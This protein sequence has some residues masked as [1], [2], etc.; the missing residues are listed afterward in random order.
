MDE[1]F[2]NQPPQVQPENQYN[3][4]AEAPTGQ[5][6]SP[7]AQPVQAA[8]PQ[9]VPVQPQQYVAPAQA[10]Q[11]NAP[12]QPQAQP[13]AQTYEQPVYQ[14]ISSAP[15]VVVGGQPK[16]KKKWLVPVVALGVVLLSGGGASAYYFGVYQK[17]ENVLLDAFNKLTAAKAVRSDTVITLNKNLSTDMT[18]KDIKLKANSAASQS[19]MM[20]AS[21]DFEYKGKAMP[22]GAKGFVSLTDSTVYFQINN[23]KEALKTVVDAENA[24]AKLPSG[25]LDGIGTL[26]DQW[27][28]VTVDD[29][30]KNNQAAG[31]NF[32]C[33]VNV[34][35]KHGNDSNQ[36]VLD[37]YK[38]NPFISVKESLGVKD[39]R[40]GY[41]L[42]W[43]DVKSKAFGDSLEQTQFVK[44]LKACNLDN[45]SSSTS[46]SVD[47]ATADNTVY[48][49]W[50]DQWTHELK[51]VEFNGTSG[52]S[53]DKM[54]FNG[55]V[56]VAYDPNVKVEAP[57]QS[58]S[59]EEFVKRYNDFAKKMGIP[60]SSYIEDQYIQSADSSNSI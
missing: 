4:E 9:P 35:K 55:S 14:P 43:D 59:L 5:V 17:P 52:T 10:Q 39:G 23:V 31:N 54:T 18:L 25:L 44:D 16:S 3:P 58:I 48:S 28:K 49:V 50:V 60:D 36:Q 19:G 13:V 2:N 38:K 51:K 26:Q 33:A 42:A 20:D 41:K 21:I 34:F 6:Q 15:P 29:L 7:F 22:M 56:D 8:E 24:A 32:E 37:L 27:V 11:F 1:Q 47:S 46:P 57:A 45:S 12:V 30:K 40:L 53:S